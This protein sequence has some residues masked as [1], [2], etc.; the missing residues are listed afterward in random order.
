[1]SLFWQFRYGR[2]VPTRQRTQVQHAEVP[3]DH[4]GRELGQRDG[5]V[6]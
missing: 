2:V 3:G 4:D 1:M 5:D 6:D